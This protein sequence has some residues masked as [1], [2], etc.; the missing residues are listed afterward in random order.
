MCYFLFGAVSKKDYNKEFLSTSLKY[1]IPVDYICD[2]DKSLLL[3]KKSTRDKNGCIFRLTNE[4]C[5]CSTPIGSRED[6]SKM[7]KNSY[8]KQKEYENNVYRI[9][10]NYINW[11]KELHNL[12][13]VNDVYF[14]KH[15]DS[16]ILDYEL[17]KE[18]I[19]I[20]DITRDFLINMEDETIY[21]IQ[22][23]KKYY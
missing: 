19:H 5:D 22:L 10:D 20:S 23:Y 21:K 8:H 13:C 7:Y 1:N 12:S 9:I 15:W 16:D 6:I 11:L 14:F 18:T 17:K 3:L 2:V 4:Y